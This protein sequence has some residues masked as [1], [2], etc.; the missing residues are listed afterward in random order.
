[1]I[2]KIKILRC[3]YILVDITIIEIIVKTISKLCSHTNIVLLYSSLYSISSTFI[4]NFFFEGSV[5]YYL[6]VSFHKEVV[7]DETCFIFTAYLFQRFL[8]VGRSFNFP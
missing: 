5:D 6:P 8:S 4:L 1:M 3:W 7:Q 2:I